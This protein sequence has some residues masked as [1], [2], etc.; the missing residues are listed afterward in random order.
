[1]ASKKGYT[2][3][4]D[5]TGLTRQERA[6]REAILAGNSATETAQQLG[7]SRTRVYQIAAARGW[8][9]PDGRRRR[10]AEN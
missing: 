10:S 2:L 4:R 1:M 9:F 7:I 6:V 8:K 3:D 5:A